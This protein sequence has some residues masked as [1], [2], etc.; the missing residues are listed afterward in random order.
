MTRDL[1]KYDIKHSLISVSEAVL[2]F[3][4]MC[5]N[6]EFK[7]R[8]RAIYQSAGLLAVDLLQINRYG[9]LCCLIRAN[10]TFLIF[11]RKF[12]KS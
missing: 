4:V 9:C 8:A 7:T 12:S 3:S 10:L 1:I 2:L 5:D 11:C 6:S